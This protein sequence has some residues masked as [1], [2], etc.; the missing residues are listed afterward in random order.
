MA[1]KHQIEAPYYPIV[2]VRGYA[3]TAAEREETFH[4]TYYGFAATSVEKRQA[5]PPEYFE[6]DM[7]EGQLIR[8]MK[9]RGYG[10]A[11]AVNRG[12]EVFHSNPARSLWVCRFYDRDY[13]GE[14]IRSIEDHAKELRDL[15]CKTIPDRLEKCDVDLGPN[16]ENFRVVL[17]AHSMGGLVCRTLLQNTLP[18][19]QQDPKRWVHRLVTLGTPHRGIDL[20]RIPEFLQRMIA[21]TL[22]PFDSNIFSEDRMRDYLKLSD[23]AFA[24]HSLGREDHPRAFPVKR[25]LC[26]IGSDYHSYNAVQQVTG[27]HSDGLVKQSHAYVVSG[28]GLAD[29]KYPDER[30]AFY[31]NVHRA[32]SGRRGIV[33]SYESFENIQRFLF[34]NIKARIS[35]E[36]IQ[37]NT[38][39]QEG[40]RDLYDFEFL[41]SIRKSGVFLHRRQQDPCENA[42]RI[43]RDEIPKKLFLHTAFMNSRLKDEDDEKFSHF[44]L[45]FRVLERRIKKGFLWD[46]EYPE[47]QIFSETLEIRV[48]DSDPASPGD[49]VEYRWLS[50]VI[51]WRPIEQDNDGAYRVALRQA[52][53][54]TGELV[55]E[56]GPWPDNALTRDNG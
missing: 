3:M 13:F 10:Y 28:P 31:A 50:D 54:I 1:G 53:A 29:G 55:I 2:Y 23:K 34:G 22:N 26:L 27:N 32:H 52:G 21:N 14:K 42:I 56:A 46:D 17:I 39:R 9:M 20:G 51:D 35:L 16:R 45:R 11:D 40:V 18:E 8:F 25:C 30:T 12:V 7:F 38:P 15:V 4:D 49:E 24:V 44:I 36:N 41:F 6:A 43:E 47:R 33:N 19:D 37:V 48:G 5:P